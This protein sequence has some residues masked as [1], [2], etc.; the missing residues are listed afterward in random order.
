MLAILLTILI[1][2]LFYL[3]KQEQ[4][5]I[6]KTTPETHIKGYEILYTDQKGDFDRTK[7]VVSEMI[8]SDKYG[9]RGKPDYIYINKSKTDL[10]PVELKS[11]KIKDNK[12]PYIGDM[13]QLIAYFLMIEDKLTIK[14]REGRI[15]YK[16]YMFIIKNTKE[17]REH[18]LKTME[19]MNNMLDTGE[20]DVS[21]S[22]VKCKH[23]MCNGTVCEFCKS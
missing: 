20:S 6:I 1:I 12:T 19:D 5:D 7:V 13:M 9:L 10:I 2:I 18:L 17:F 8:V 15:I 11:G 14:P 16:D 3:F 22:F 21:P 23:C 4:N